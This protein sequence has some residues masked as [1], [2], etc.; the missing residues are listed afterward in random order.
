MFLFF[1]FL[2]MMGGYP[3]LC[4]FFV[5]IWLIACED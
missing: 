5:I 2:A 1:A 3:W 4:V